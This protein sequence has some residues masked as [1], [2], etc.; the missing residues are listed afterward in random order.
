MR[1]IRWL[2][3]FVALVAAACRSA[4]TST[5]ADRATGLVGTSWRAE[6]INGRAVDIAPATLSF[7]SPTRVSGRASCNLYAAMLT[8]A[9][10]R[11]RIERLSTSRMACPPP[12]MDQEHRFLTALVEVVSLHRHG[13]RLLLIDE[14]GR[15]RLALGPS[16]AGR[17]GAPG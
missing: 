10:D 6:Q 11:V 1:R 7:D 3:V 17:R 5:T 12:V 4:S 16:S 15:V 2:L 14:D 8:L 9:G 13:E